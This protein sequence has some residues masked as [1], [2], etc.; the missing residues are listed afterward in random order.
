MKRSGSYALSG[1][2]GVAPWTSPRAGRPVVSCQARWRLF[3]LLLAVAC[4]VGVVVSHMHKSDR[5]AVRRRQKVLGRAEAL[6]HAPHYGAFKRADNTNTNN[7]STVQS[8]R[9]ALVSDLDKVSKIS[10]GKEKAW[11]SILKTGVLERGGPRA[12]LV[13]WE[14]EVPL[15]SRLSE[16]GRGMELSELLYFQG[17]LLACSDRTG[18]VYQVHLQVRRA[19]EMKIVRFLT[20]PP[21]LFRTGSLFLYGF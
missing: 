17:M 11:M 3:A 14:S 15:V 18:V 10:V 9:I 20:F 19:S 5:K 6:R 2:V 12:A 4:V 1:L 8:Y 7:A 16:G 21:F 13:R